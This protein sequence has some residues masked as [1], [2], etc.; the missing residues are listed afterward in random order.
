MSM[1][2]IIDSDAS[3]EPEPITSF[4]HSWDNMA[5][6]A[7]GAQT[8]AGQ[9][10]SSRTRG[11]A[12]ACLRAC[13]LPWKQGVAARWE[14]FGGV[15]PKLRAGRNR[16]DVTMPAASPAAAQPRHGCHQE[17][18]ISARRDIVAIDVMRSSPS[19]LHMH[20]TFLIEPVKPAAL[21]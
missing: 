11:I 3:G 21:S 2:N 8:S 1:N 6:P 20:V 16:L 14:E 13:V 12:S 10:T 5:Y 19:R 4:C 18:R 9:S 15:D 17:T 7:F